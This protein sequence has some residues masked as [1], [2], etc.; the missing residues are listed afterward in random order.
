[1]VGRSTGTWIEREGLRTICLPS[2]IKETS[3]S[4]KF[5]IAIGIPMIVRHSKIP[6][7][8]CVSASHQPATD[9]PDD[10]AEEGEDPGAWLVDQLTAEGPR[11]IA[12]HTE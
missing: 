2:G 7:A 6:V 11:R 12:R 3:I 5:A 1:M 10:I 8:M 9:H 4:L